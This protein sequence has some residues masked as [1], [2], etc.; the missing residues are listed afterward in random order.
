VP[1]KDA[2]AYV[3]NR[4]LT[5]LFGEVLRAIDDGTDFLVAD[6]ALDPLGLPMSPLTLVGF[7]GAA[8]TLHVAESL[9]AAYPDRF[10]VS[11]N[12]RQVVDAGKSSILTWVGGEPVVDPEVTALYER[13][14]DPVLLGP[15]QI[16]RRAVGAVCDEVRRLLDDGV[17]AE[18]QDIDLCL[19][20]G[21]GFPFHLGGLT[22]Y[23]DRAGVSEHVTGRRFLSPGV[24]SLRASPD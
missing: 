6:R 9:A 3:V 8:V 17:V 10:Y 24:A 21:A 13:P 2:P 15:D 16:L 22:P 19:L 11:A 4:L 14:A 5:R 1:V 23:L 18:A 12:L 20:T 7:T